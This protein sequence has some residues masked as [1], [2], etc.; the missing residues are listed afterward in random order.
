MEQA[1]LRLHPIERQL[2]PLRK[3]NLRLAIQF[4]REFAE[5]RVKDLLIA[6]VPGASFATLGVTK[7]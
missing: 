4:A 2:Q 6:R 1:F 5:V 3:I 7:L